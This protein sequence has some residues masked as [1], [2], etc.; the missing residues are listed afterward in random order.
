MGTELLVLA[1][2][3]LL[4]IVQMSLQSFTYKAQVGNAYTVG[5]RDQPVP[6]AG[7][8]GRADRA[9]RNLLESLPVFAIAVIVAQLAGKTDDWTALGAWIFLGARIAFVPAYLAGWPWVRTLI[10]N[11]SMVGVVLIYWRILA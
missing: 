9:Y 10:W 2:V 7:L 6:P 4:A 3:G 5:P 8:A 11:A 1:L